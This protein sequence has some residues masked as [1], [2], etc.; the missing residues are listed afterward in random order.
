MFEDYSAA[1]HDYRSSQRDVKWH[2]VMP[3][4][5][6][7]HLTPGLQS[8]ATHSYLTVIAERQ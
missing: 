5:L 8:F 1:V 3:T 6:M 7:H 4:N 2:C